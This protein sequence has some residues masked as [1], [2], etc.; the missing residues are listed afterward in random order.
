MTLTESPCVPVGAYEP[1][2]PEWLALRRSGIGSSDAAAALGLSPWSSPYSLWLEKTDQFDRARDE[3]GLE[4]MAWGH[5]LES[6]V[7]AEFFERHPEF[8]ELLMAPETFRST[9]WPF[10]LATPDRFM[11][12]A[13]TDDASQRGVLEVKTTSAF[14]ARD[15]SRGVP[16]DVAVQVHHQLAVTG[17]S[18]AFVAV[19]V[20]GQRYADFYLERDEALI[21]E[22]VAKEEGFWRLVGEGTPPA[23]D[24]APATTEAVRQV[25]GESEPGLSVELPASAAELIETVRS[26]SAHA[27]Q[28]TEKAQEAKNA[29]ALLLGQAE[30]GTLNG[31]RVLTYRSAEVS[32][33]D[34]KALR[35]TEP[36]LAERFT[37]TT[38][39]RTMRL[40]DRKG[41]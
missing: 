39:T 13:G 37:K 6:L 19:L 12:F 27:A 25:V 16:D 32:R 11:Q 33:I 20:G 35:A 23:V 40:V 31:E 7:A 9:R 2:S 24:G 30:E 36:A 29:L 38:T 17:L 8:E 4:Q 3:E 28:W 14:L 1:D 26:A 18:F 34:A 10:M 41:E 5:K 22:L 21:R 15:W